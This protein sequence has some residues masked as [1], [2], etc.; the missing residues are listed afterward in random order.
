[1]LKIS[2]F[3]GRG[4]LL[5]LTFGIILD[6]GSGNK[7]II[8]ATTPIIGVNVNSLPEIA[9]PCQ[10]LF[11]DFESDFKKNFERTEKRE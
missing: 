6:N 9:A 8:L 4:L 11:G 7:N 2:T 1:M 10:P 5:G 3:F